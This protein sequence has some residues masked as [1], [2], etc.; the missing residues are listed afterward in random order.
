LS[1]KS[2]CDTVRRW[3][4]W[5]LLSAANYGMVLMTREPDAY[6]QLHI[7]ATPAS[8]IMNHANYCAIMVMI[9]GARYGWGQGDRVWGLISGQGQHI[10]LGWGEDR[11]QPAFTSLDL[12]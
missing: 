4:R 5:P 7:A 10:G 6:M 9:F 11:D 1:L 12:L 2:T 3:R 8:G